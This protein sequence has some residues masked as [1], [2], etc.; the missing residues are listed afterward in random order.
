MA[1]EEG[2]TQ[3][4]KDSKD[5]NEEDFSKPL[6]SSIKKDESSIDKKK[7]EKLMERS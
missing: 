4:L 1:D 5:S 7:K 2:N 3:I 6:A